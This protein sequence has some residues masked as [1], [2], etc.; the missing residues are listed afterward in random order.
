MAVDVPVAQPP[1]APQQPQVLR[2][3]AADIVRLDQVAFVA[4]G[5]GRGEG[6]AGEV[7]E[8]R[9]G[10]DGRTVAVVVDDRVHVV[11][12]DHGVVVI[13]TPRPETAQDVGDS[14]R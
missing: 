4:P 6:V 2:A 12:A 1:A 7:T 11:P 8:V 14:G 13:R 5:S 3:A 10:S 9:H